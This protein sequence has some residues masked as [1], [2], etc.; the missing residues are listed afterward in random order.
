MLVTSEGTQKASSRKVMMSENPSPLIVGRK[1]RRKF[2]A[3]KAT[4]VIK[5]EKVVRVL[6]RLSKR[7]P[8]F[9]EPMLAKLVPTLP[10]GGEWEYELKFDGYRSQCVKSGSTVQLFSRNENSF[11]ERYAQ[12]LPL[13][14]GVRCNNVVIDGEIVALDEK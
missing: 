11:T 5:N 8:S 9:V 7:E 2:Q 10:E 4:R 14:H 3:D 13:F 6:S 12:L 1:R